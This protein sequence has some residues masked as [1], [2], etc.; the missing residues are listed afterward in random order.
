[1]HSLRTRVWKRREVGQAASQVRKSWKAVVGRELAS[2]FASVKAAER[3]ASLGRSP[4]KSAIRLATTALPSKG[5]TASR[6]LSARRAW[7]RVPRSEVEKVRSASCTASLAR[8][9]RFAC[10][11][12]LRGRAGRPRCRLL[13]RDSNISRR[14]SQQ[15]IQFQKAGLKVPCAHARN[16]VGIE[17]W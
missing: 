14:Y 12:S 9:S 4:A 3:A 13:A 8:S 11:P 10:S 15:G 6:I 16:M 5:K 2:F 17:I 7:S 1:M